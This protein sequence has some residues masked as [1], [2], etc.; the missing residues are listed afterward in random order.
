M[1]E[2]LTGLPILLHK[3]QMKAIDQ[4]RSIH[5]RYTSGAEIGFYDNDLSEWFSGTIQVRMNI[6]LCA[7]SFRSH[8][9]I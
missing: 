5:Q 8:P 1:T 9:I 4:T 3:S 2:S 7:R 6:K